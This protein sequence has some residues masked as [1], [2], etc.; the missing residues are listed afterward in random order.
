MLWCLVFHKIEATEKDPPNNVTSAQVSVTLLDENDNSPSFNSSKYEGKVFADQTVGMLLVQVGQCISNSISYL[1][2]EFYCMF[3][4]PHN[5]TTVS[6]SW[7]TEATY[8]YWTFIIHVNILCLITLYDRLIYMLCL[9][10]AKVEGTF[11][12]FLHN[13]SRKVET[14]VQYVCRN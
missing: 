3:Q 14:I 1:P 4:L 10:K 5:T 8:W 9:S 2:F 6:L 13:N 7:I 12:N 11:F